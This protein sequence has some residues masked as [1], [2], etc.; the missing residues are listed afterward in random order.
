[1]TEE[2]DYDYEIDPEDLPARLPPRPLGHPSIVVDSLDVTYKVYGSRR[3]GTTDSAP[4]SLVRRVLGGSRRHIG[5]VTYVK[6]V[7][8]VSFVARHGE[9][10]GIVG[11]NGSGKSTLLRAIAGLI[12]PTRGRVFVAGEP[13]LL[14]VNAVLMRELSG[15]R[16]IM[17][18]GLALG[19]T[20]KEIR[21]QMPDITEFAD[22]GDFIYL[23][24]SAYSSGMQSRLRF[25]ISTFSSPDILMIDEALAT[26]DAA[27]RERSKERIDQIRQEA[28]TIFFVSHSLASV[29]AMCTRVIWLSEGEV[30]RDG[31]VDEVCDAYYEHILQIRADRTHRR[32]L[33]R[34]AARLSES[35]T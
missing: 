21:E 31:P 25:A 12:P 30:V 9:A 24:M 33:A 7:R 5:A 18:G 29:R 19:M 13:T 35:I 11:V 14:G 10:I 28:G 2:N 34:Q 3:I 17:I 23:P 26:G 32:R 22:I 20:I 4:K 8:N 27:F 1:V 16:N 15:E 6:A